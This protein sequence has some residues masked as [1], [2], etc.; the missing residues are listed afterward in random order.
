ME[1]HSDHGKSASSEQE[2]PILRSA[3]LCLGNRPSNTIMYSQLTPRILGSLIAL[4]EHKVFVEGVLLNINSF[5]QWGVELGKAI[6]NE[7]L[8][9]LEES[10]VNQDNF[11]KNMDSSTKGLI[12]FFH[13][14]KSS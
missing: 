4:Y 10:S 7:I 5:D 6:M 12:Q 8:P 13:N 9:D 11:K 2:D 3:K 14:K 1:G